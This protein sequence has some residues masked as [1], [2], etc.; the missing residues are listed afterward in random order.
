MDAEPEI[1][2]FYHLARN[3]M[4]RAFLARHQADPSD[5]LPLVVAADWLDEQGHPEIASIL[6]RHHVW[7]EESKKDMLVTGQGG[8]HYSQ[9]I[10]SVYDPES[11]THVG[12]SYHPWRVGGKGAHGLSFGVWDMRNR[13]RVIAAH[14]PA[15]K[16][17]ILDAANRYGA[18]GADEEMKNH[19]H[20]L[21]VWKE[22]P[23][24]PEQLAATPTAP[25]GNSVVVRVPLPTP[26]GGKP[27]QPAAPA[28]RPAA[29]PQQPAA[30]SARSF[31]L[32]V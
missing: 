26:V 22:A 18:P 15:T 6:R 32:P 10:S 25:G 4:F 20:N 17:E 27:A 28:P 29:I 5:R 8:H 31:I 1:H 11:G 21:R 23:E 9:P 24:S 19:L 30:P 14:S 3:P 13:K 12:I 7:A 16:Q 2:P